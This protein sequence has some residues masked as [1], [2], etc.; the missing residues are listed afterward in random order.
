MLGFSIAFD[1]R[2]WE[3]PQVM[4]IFVEKMMAAMISGCHVFRQLISTSFMK[5]HG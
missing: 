4:A 3:L 5:K 2:G 1:F